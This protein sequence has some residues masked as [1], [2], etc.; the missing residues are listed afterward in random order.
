MASSVEVPRFYVPRSTFSIMPTSEAWEGNDNR[1]LGD[2]LDKFS[3]MTLV[4]LRKDGIV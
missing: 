4:Q 1:N 2:L 3:V